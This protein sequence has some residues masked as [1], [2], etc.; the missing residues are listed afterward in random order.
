VYVGDTGLSPASQDPGIPFVREPCAEK[1]KQRGIFAPVTVN[2][3]KPQNGA[4][5]QTGIIPDHFLRLPF[6][7]GIRI[8]GIGGTQ[9]VEQIVRVLIE[10]AGSQGTGEYESFDIQ[11]LCQLK[12]IPGTGHIGM[13]I[14]G[15]IVHGEII[16]PGQVQDIIGTTIPV[17]ALDDILQ[18]GEIPDVYLCPAN[19]LMFGYA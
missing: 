17:Y 4:G 12:H 11:V 7:D 8:I 9:F 2:C 13:F 16:V 3:C 15:I 5:E 19:I 10:L 6:T 18:V 14:L 1:Y